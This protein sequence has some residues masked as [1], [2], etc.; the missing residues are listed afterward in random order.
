MT[1]VALCGY[2]QPAVHS[3]LAARSALLRPCEN[4]NMAY[5]KKSPPE[6]AETRRRYLWTPT[7]G[8]RATLD[9]K[10]WLD[11]VHALSLVL[12]TGAVFSHSTA[13]VLL[14]L[15]LPEV[16]PRPFHFTS[17]VKARRG[18]RK[19]V[20][21]HQRPIEGQTLVWNE[22][23]VTHPVRTWRDLAA[24]LDVAHLV[25]VADV[26][27][28]R[29]WCDRELLLKLT[30]LRHIAKLRCAA[31]LA[32]GGSW[33]PKESEM[34]VAM[35]DAGL[36]R[37]ELNGLIVEDGLVIGT[38]DLVW[39]KYK[40]IADYDGGHHIRSDQRH[41][42]A[43]TRDDYSAAGWRHV[44]LTSKMSHHQA[45]ERTKRALRQHGWDG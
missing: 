17:D 28:R 29:Q 45:V 25:A 15:P 12:P 27:L 18:R 2:P 39:R 7:R 24:T 21:W 30:G 41:Q 38:G 33:S 8:V 1:R 40:T 14:D 36:P 19:N 13:A 35:H 34:R 5:L 31:E 44:A 32:D 9:E 6:D 26:L 23:P 42:D 20:S 37:P 4:G 43:Q 22:F 16:D 11:E 3:F 10:S